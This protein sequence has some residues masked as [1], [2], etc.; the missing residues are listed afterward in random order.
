[1]TFLPLKC[2]L[3]SKASCFP[4]NRESFLIGIPRLIQVIVRVFH[5]REA[6]VPV[7]T[8]RS[9]RNLRSDASIVMSLMLA[10]RRFI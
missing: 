9:Q 4:T 7:S 3:L 10:K 5:E 8:Y 6:S 2:A 1:M